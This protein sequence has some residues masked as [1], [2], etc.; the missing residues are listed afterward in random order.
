[1]LRAH[2]GGIFPYSDGIVLD[3]P[4]VYTDVLSVDLQCS[5]D[6]HNFDDCRSDLEFISC[7]MAYC[8]NV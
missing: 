8:F 7:L 1:M 6:M 3:L 4:C 2:H 5:V